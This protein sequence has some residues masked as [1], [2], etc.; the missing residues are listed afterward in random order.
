MGPNLNSPS[1]C[2]AQTHPTY[3]H[4]VHILLNRIR[5]YHCRPAPAAAPA[6]RPAA[7]AAAPACRP[8]A[9]PAPARRPLPD[10]RN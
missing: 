9:A 6:C 3:S 1:T 7:A 8:A 5:H 10:N 4:S 2:I